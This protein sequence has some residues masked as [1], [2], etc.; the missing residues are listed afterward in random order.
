M[1]HQLLVS[2]LSELSLSFD[3]RNANEMWVTLSAQFLKHVFVYHN[4]LQVGGREGEDENALVDATML[5]HLVY[6]PALTPRGWALFFSY[7]GRSRTF[8]F[9]N[10]TWK[11]ITI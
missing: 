7:V 1:N 3:Y 10:K 2:G 6:G 4:D 11:W 5:Q 9:L 8:P